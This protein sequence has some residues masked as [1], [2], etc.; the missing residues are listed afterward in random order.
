MS[1][2]SFGLSFKWREWEHGHLSSSCTNISCLLFLGKGYVTCAFDKYKGCFE[3]YYE[4]KKNILIRYITYK[5][6]LSKIYVHELCNLIYMIIL[7]YWYY[8]L[9]Y[10]HIIWEWSGYAIV[11][12][13]LCKNKV[14]RKI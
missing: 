13:H 6:D 12:K 2:I 5:H 4:L 8:Y 11:V 10:E 9:Y 3:N 14:I 1:V 7:A